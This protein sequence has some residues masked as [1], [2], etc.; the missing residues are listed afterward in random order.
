MSELE[1][2]ILKKLAKALPLFDERQKLKM[3][4][5]ADMALLM[6]VGKEPELKEKLA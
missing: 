4:G 2:E 5:A 3:L 6:K 1:K